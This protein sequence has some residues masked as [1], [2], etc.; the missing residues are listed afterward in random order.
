MAVLPMAI[1][2]RAKKKPKP[3]RVRRRT[4]DQNLALSVQVCLDK[5]ARL[6]QADEI[7]IKR[8]AEMQAEI[9]QLRALVE[10]KS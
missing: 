2:R 4:E 6:E 10:T 7:H 5:I 3:R 9:D 1:F 8:M